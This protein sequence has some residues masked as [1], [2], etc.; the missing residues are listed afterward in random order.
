LAQLGNFLRILLDQMVDNLALKLVV[1]VRNLL[2]VFLVR[3]MNLLLFENS[4]DFKKLSFLSRNILNYLL[5]FLVFLELDKARLVL[6]H[7][8]QLLLQSHC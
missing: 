2:M 8:A 4:N 3:R 7:L 1:E 5:R 6:L